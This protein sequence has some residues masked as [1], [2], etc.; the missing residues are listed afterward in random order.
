MHLLK[1]DAKQDYQHAL[2]KAYFKKFG[3]E[4]KI[5]E[6]ELEDGVRRIH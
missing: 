1:E 6:A 2:S 3:K 5:F 4:A